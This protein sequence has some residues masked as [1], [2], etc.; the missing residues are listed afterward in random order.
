[1]EDKFDANISK[2]IMRELCTK[3][4]IILYCFVNHKHP[5]ECCLWL[6]RNQNSSY[7]RDLNSAVTKQSN[8][9]DCDIEKKQ[10][11]CMIINEQLDMI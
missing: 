6:K 7:L 5:C 4:T 2:Y 8:I 11:Y 3:I 9:N 1:M 10:I